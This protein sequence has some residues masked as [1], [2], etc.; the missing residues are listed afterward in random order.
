VTSA[1]A[2]P[3]VEN[4]LGIIP[5]KTGFKFIGLPEM[6]E[7]SPFKLYTLSKDGLSMISIRT[8]TVYPNSL[9]PE[10]NSVTAT[11][12]NGPISLSAEQAQAT[13]PLQYSSSESLRANRNETQG[14]RGEWSSIAWK[15]ERRL[16]AAFEQRLIQ[17]CMQVLNLIWST[18]EQ[19]RLPMIQVKET[20]ERLD[21]LFS[22]ISG[23]PLDGND[24]ILHSISHSELLQ[25]LLQR[26]EEYSK[27]NKN[28]VIPTTDHAEINKIIAYII[29]N[30]DKELSLGDLARYVSM[31]DNYVSNLFKRKTGKTVVQYIQEVRVEQAKFYLEQT[32]LTVSEIV[33][34]VGFGN[35][36][37][38]FKIFKRFTGKTPNDYRIDY[39]RNKCET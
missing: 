18:M 20:A 14:R 23:I 2:S 19:E 15:D 35:D 16:L 13:L 30:F 17:D 27:A 26:M 4:I 3:L 9:Y 34:R 24:A 6:P 36:N 7:L 37:Y 29:R 8:D 25:L 22:R 31:D 1:A 38:F 32:G 33:E 39:L 12:L 5:D 10:T 28:H 11:L 21:K